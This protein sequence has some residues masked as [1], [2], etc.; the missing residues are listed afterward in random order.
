[1]I[2]SKSLDEA[3]KE[4]IRQKAMGSQ[5]QVLE[6]LKKKGIEV[7]QSTVSRA[8][9]RV[10]A[11]RARSVSGKPTYQLNEDAAPVLS[12]FASFV[13][14]ISTNG[15]AVVVH[16]TAGS[17]SLVA[18]HLDLSRHPEIM[19]TIAGDDTILV[20]PAN[21]KAVDKTIQAIRDVLE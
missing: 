13:L 5:T 11:V 9:S 4:L 8:L 14:D 6:A 12:S 7:N 10:G 15:M 2:G 17:A 18:R 16:T 21:L 20:L 3:V 1:M 19:G